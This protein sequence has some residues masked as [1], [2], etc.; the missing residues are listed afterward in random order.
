MSP[1]VSVVIPTFNSSQLLHEAIDSVLAQTMDDYEI[2]V[3]D[4]GSTDDTRDMIEAYE[5]RIRYLRQ[6]RCGASMAR[7]IGVS[8]SVGKYI[9]ALDA[10][11]IWLPAKLR[12]Q[13]EAMETDPQ[14][15]LCYTDGYRWETGRAVTSSPRLSQIYGRGRSGW[16]FSFM[17]K[18]AA[19]STS[20]MF[21]RRSAYDAV[22]GYDVSL[23][24]CDAEFLIRLA[25]Y[26]PFIYIPEAL[27]AYR[28]HSGNS[29]SAVHKYNA[30]TNLRFL[31]L[32][33]AKA[34]TRI[35]SDMGD[36]STR[37]YR[38]GPDFLQWLLLLYWRLTYGSFRFTMDRIV[39]YIRAL[40]LPEKPS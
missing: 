22:G 29:S 14:A 19:A 8:K 7:S 33:R 40:A 24:Y 37:L 32:I 18:I 13:V 9:A 3:V 1:L 12:C 10:D 16:Q 21:F 26:Y 28:V 2:I 35:P 34:S 27:M 23:R 31:R 17:F 20:S 5:D 25:A 39:S 38:R 36:F 30:A 4:D 15:G 11:D 6:Q